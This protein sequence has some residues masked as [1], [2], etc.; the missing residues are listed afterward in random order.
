[1][2]I[3]VMYIYIC[4]IDVTP[5]HPSLSSFCSLYF[6]HLGFADPEP[7]TSSPYTCQ[8]RLPWETVI[9]GHAVETKKQ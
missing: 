7:E 5:H 8:K 1:M 6:P 2:Y 4:M 3:S 9:P